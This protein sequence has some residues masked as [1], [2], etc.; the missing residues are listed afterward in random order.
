[1]FFG[2]TQAAR[3]DN[4]GNNNRQTKGC[5]LDWPDGKKFTRVFAPFQ[6]ECDANHERAM[7]VAGNIDGAQ[8]M[9]WGDAS[10]TPMLNIFIT[11]SQ[12]VRCNTGLIIPLCI[13]PHVAKHVRE[14][15][16]RIDVLEMNIAH[17]FGF[18]FY[19]GANSREEYGRMLY[20]VFVSLVLLCS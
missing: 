19:N 12:D 14:C 8:T 9:S 7:G 6:R 15:F 17:E 16:Y 1:M 5:F 3:Q 13:I 18:P 2:E 10:L 20:Y 11:F 4:H